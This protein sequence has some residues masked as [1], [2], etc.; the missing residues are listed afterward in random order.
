MTPEP[1]AVGDAFRDAIARRDDGGAARFASPLVTAIVADAAAGPRE[2]LAPVLE[3]IVST[4]ASAGV[5]RGRQFVLFVHA[6]GSRAE[7][8]ARGWREALGVPALFHDPDGATFSVRPGPIPIEL[9]DELREAE[10]IVSVGPAHSSP[11]VMHGGPLLLCPGAAGSRTV[12]SW[13]RLREAVGLEEAIRLSIEVECMAPVDLAVTWDADGQVTV[14][15]G[16]E[17][18]ASLALAAGWRCRVS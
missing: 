15:P 12:A 7:G 13:R 8:D 17:R 16:R 18:F 5:P 11:G 6:D 14:A 3:A 1:A 4:L 9:D 2:T 10:A